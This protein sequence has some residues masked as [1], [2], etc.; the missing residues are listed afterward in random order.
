VGTILH[1]GEL[2]GQE[3]DYSVGLSLLGLTFTGERPQE[4]SPSAQPGE[5]VEL[6]Q[7]KR[8]LALNR[9]M[10]EIVSANIKEYD[11]QNRFVRPVVKRMF[12]QGTGLK[13]EAWLALAQGMTS[14]L[15]RALE[16]ARAGQAALDP[17]WVESYLGYLHCMVD[18]ISKQEG[19][20]RGWIKDQA[21]LQAALAALR[22][23]KE[24]VRS[25][26]SVLAEALW[27]GKD[28]AP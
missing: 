8:A 11:E 13:V 18:Y 24:T 9:Q 14:R 2:H 4:P 20:A 7:V 5:L 26:V 25:L 16:S 1:A 10:E 12:Q 21:Q 3:L 22:E 23:R 17:A 28:S 15:E 19:D 27:E 6:E